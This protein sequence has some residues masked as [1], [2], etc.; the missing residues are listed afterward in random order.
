[1]ANKLILYRT[2]INRAFVNA[3]LR[4]N[5]RHRIISFSLS[6]RLLAF[7]GEKKKKIIVIYKHT[8][9]RQQQFTWSLCTIK[10][11][12]YFITLIKVGYSVFCCCN[13]F[14]CYCH[15][16]CVDYYYFIRIFHEYGHFGC[17]WYMCLAFPEALAKVNT[18]HLCIVGINAIHCR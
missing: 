6:V 3:Q 11:C 14:D 17:R 13:Y 9:S 2:H 18:T 4:T 12:Y 5:I 8:Y 16:A 7:I 1:M 10:N 15:F